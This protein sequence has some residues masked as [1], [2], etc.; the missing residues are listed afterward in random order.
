MG[1]L[2]QLAGGAQPENQTKTAQAP[3]SVKRDARGRLV[4]GGANLNPGGRKKGTEAELRAM[5]DAEGPEGNSHARLARILNGEIEVDTRIFLETYRW[6]FERA[7]GKAL[8]RSASVNVDLA[9]GEAALP[10]DRMPEG[11]L[12]ALLEASQGVVGALPTGLS[13]DTVEGQVVLPD[14]DSN[15]TVT[16]KS[17]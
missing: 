6:A 10:L 1:V 5:L 12:G 15:E 8:E 9:G 16:V 2:S 11:I 7:N 13:P 3:K 4:P 17:Q 14:T